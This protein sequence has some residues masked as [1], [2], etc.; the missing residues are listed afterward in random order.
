MPQS[1]GPEF[2][3]PLDILAEEH[4]VIRAVVDAMEK[5]VTREEEGRLF[6]GRWWGHV[7]EFFEGFVERGHLPKEEQALYPTVLEAAPERKAAIDE[8]LEAHREAR[9]L[10]EALGAAAELANE[11]GVEAAAH[12]LIRT[13]RAAL[14]D[15][16][17]VLETAWKVLTEPQVREL[18][19]RFAEF[20]DEGIGAEGTGATSC[21]PN[22]SARK[23]TRPSRC[24][25][26]GTCS[27]RPAD[28]TDPVAGRGLTSDVAVVGGGL[29]GVVT[30]LELLDRGRRVTLLERAG[31]ERLGGL[32]RESFGGMFFVDTPEQRRSGVRDGVDLAL[33]DWLSTAEFDE[34]DVWPRRWAEYYVERCTAEV[35]G[36]LH[37]RGVRFF[38]VVHWVERGLYVPGNSVPR[39]HMVWGTGK[40]LVEA[41][42]ERIESHPARSRLQILCGHRVVDLTRSAGRFDGCVALG[43]EG[44]ITVRAEAV[45]LASGGIA[46]NLELVR[47]HWPREW[48]AP[49]EDLLNGSHPEA[50]GA[51]HELVERLGGRVTHLDRMWHY[52]AGVR[53]WRPRHPRHGLSL[54][55]PKS[56]LWVDWRGRRLG[57][58]PLVT[59]Y[60]T[61]YLVET[62]CRQEKPY[63]WQIL[64]R[65]IARRELAVS[66]AEF[67]AAIRER[68][69]VRFVLG[70]LLGSDALVDEFVTHCPDFVT[71]DSLP[72]LAARMN[73]LT[74]TDDVDPGLLAHEV[75][76]YDA[77]IA[78]GPAFHNDDQLRRIAQARRYRGD[79]IRT[80]KAAPIDD[81]AGR[82]L[83]AIHERIVTR[84]S[85]GGM[86]T[87]LSCRVL[88]ENGAPLPG[89]YAV[90]EAAGFGG[91]G[92]HGRRS[93]EGTFLGGCVLTGRVA[94]RHPGG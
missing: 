22:A 67:N 92:M 74:G 42:L 91:G 86:Q 25:A 78:R 61:R 16:D 71:A 33:S 11:E 56:A 49:P 41:L 26:G 81:P 87:D 82:P 14:A 15:E 47:A 60:D 34:Q 73:E 6:R 94:A 37:A 8:I 52:A 93:L 48:G 23:W 50:D 79:R 65:R 10:R 90:G 68:R 83:I 12:A 1:S 20:E 45:V 51:L 38:P 89:L 19:R 39:F 75:R 9:S 63:S 17:G 85:L 24:A 64:N 84:K 28:R 62:V 46:G 31:P 77:G 13:E 27:K 80:C 57:P 36:W 70:T 5:E 7:A 35:R 29:A 58:P 76:R 53:H 4:L 72:E 44:E 69:P 55:P 30:A 32:A 43:P 66:G 3:H 2:E 88:G 18:A 59:G 21:W 40:R 54:V